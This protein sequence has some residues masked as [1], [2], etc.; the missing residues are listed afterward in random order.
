MTDTTSRRFLLVRSEDA[1]GTSGTGTVAEGTRFR[2]GTVALRW[3][4]ATTSTAL[5]ASIGDVIAIHGH[6]GRTTIHWLDE[7]PTP[8]S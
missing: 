1:T 6:E 8:C 7:E 5:Y 4:T 2:D 3:L